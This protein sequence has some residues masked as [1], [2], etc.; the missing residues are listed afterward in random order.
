[1]RGFCCF[2]LC[3]TVRKIAF[4]WLWDDSLWKCL[5]KKNVLRELFFY[6]RASFYCKTS[7]KCLVLSQ[8][9]NR[10]F[11]T[12]AET[13]NKGRKLA[14]ANLWARCLI[15]SWLSRSFFVPTSNLGTS[16]CKICWSA[17]V[18]H[19]GMFRKL[20]SLKMGLKK[21]IPKKIWPSNV[22]NKND[23]S[24][25]SVVVWDHRL[26]ESLL[27]CCIPD[28]ES[29]SFRVHLNAFFA[30]IN[31]DGCFRIAWKS[32]FDKSVRQACL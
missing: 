4:I 11:Q 12:F 26:A 15:T 14:S 6:I 10:M 13:S 9:H 16:V 5:W 8:G 27:P 29:D 24:S 1:M 23:G 31:A 2:N 3:A 30:E 18:I 22:V 28:L 21:F 17:S 7:M 20:C 32:F 19:F 25:V